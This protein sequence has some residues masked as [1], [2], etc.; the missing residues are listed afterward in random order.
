MTTH[1]KIKPEDIAVA[2]VQK[3]KLSS[4]RNYLSIEL[5]PLSQYNN[6]IITGRN[7]SGKTNILE[8]ISLLS[9]GKGIRGCKLSEI[10][11]DTTQ[12]SCWH[13]DAEIASFYGHERI[14]TWLDPQALEDG[15]SKR[16]VKVNDQSIKT[17]A[18]LTKLLTISWITPQMD[19]LFIS[20][21]STRRK[22]L[23]RIVQNFEP[24]HAKHL[25]AYEHAMRERARLLKDKN[26]DINWLS[27][28]EN[29]MAEVAIPIAASRV[30]TAEYVEEI[31]G[32]IDHPFP[33]AR[34]V[35]DGEIE[36][37]MHK[38]PAVQLEDEFRG[39]LQKNRGLDAAIGR[40]NVGVHKSDLLVYYK[41]K[42]LQAD[43]CSTGE[44]KSLLLSIFLA[45]VF[46]QIKWRAQ[47]PI[48][49][50]DEVLAHLDENRRDILCQVIKD[51]KAQTWITGTESEIFTPIKNES[52]FFKIENSKLISV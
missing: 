48:L 40:T 36:S 24:S 27:V 7:G 46:A 32:E 6:I 17:Q 14:E 22:F 51:T 4:F 44:Q 5:K 21:A 50:L 34:M 31:M 47:T 26:Y 43:K 49:L 52:Q 1:K 39:S 15:R 8:A 35:V 37:K 2:K 9:P 12:G 33:K 30:Q 28:L 11:N 25:M 16:Q 20:G 3:L 41:G 13:I 19:Q 42:N 10:S 29:N 45:E 38:V 18:E 23:D